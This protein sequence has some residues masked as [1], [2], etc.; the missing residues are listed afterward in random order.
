[1]T[2]L[3]YRVSCTFSPMDMLPMRNIIITNGQVM[4]LHLINLIHSNNLNPQH[5]LG[6]S[7]QYIK[8][9]YSAQEGR[10]VIPLVR[11]ISAAQNLFNP[12]CRYKNRA[13][14]IW[15]FFP[16]NYLVIKTNCF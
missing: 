16:A 13:I 7:A 11:T 15:I 1:M 6:Y 12:S 3:L 5:Q 4:L 9:A 10:D 2:G 14:N 8:T